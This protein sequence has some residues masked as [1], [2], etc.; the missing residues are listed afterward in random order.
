VEEKGVREYAEAAR[1]VDGRARFVWVGP[2]DPDKPDALRGD[3]D[4]VRLLGERRDMP[5]IY[6]ALDVFVLPSYREGFSRSAMEAAACGTAMVL[7]DIRGC[8]EI[9]SDGEHLLLVPPRDP[10]RLAQA[11]EILVRDERSRE[12]LSECALAR[13]R[14][15]FDQRRVARRSLTTYAEVARRKGLGWE[16]DL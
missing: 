12:K 14:E 7:S 6:N 8:R 1:T 2:E 3:L 4:G 11:I 5:R 16:V 15:E 9:G 10:A 13:A